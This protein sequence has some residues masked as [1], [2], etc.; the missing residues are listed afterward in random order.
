MG[1]HLVKALVLLNTNPGWELSLVEELSRVEGV[2]GV[3]VVY[4]AYDIIVEVEA[5]SM[6]ELKDV[7]VNRLRR[8]Y[9][10]SALVEEHTKTCGL[11]SKYRSGKISSSQLT[12]DE[13]IHLLN[14]VQGTVG[15]KK[16]IRSTLT[17]PV[18][19]SLEGA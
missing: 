19:E 14:P 17:L 8:N 9:S 11:C 6:R 16:G 1:A 13:A 3:H 12:R 10:E 2:V 7:V 5:K 15:L 4:G 18:V